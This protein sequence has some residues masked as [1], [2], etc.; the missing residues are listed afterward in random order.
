MSIIQFLKQKLMKSLRLN[1]VAAVT[2]IGLVGI[3]LLTFALVSGF[4]SPA[5]AEERYRN[6]VEL[7]AKTEEEAF[8]MIAEAERTRCLA[9]VD[10]ATKKVKAFYDEER[11]LQEG[12]DLQALVAKSQLTCDETS[13]VVQTAIEEVGNFS[14]PEGVGIDAFLAKNGAS[15]VKEAGDIFREA[16]KIHGI[17]PE[18]IVCI[19]QA[20]SSLGRALKSSNNIGNVGN[21]DRGDVVH[22]PDLRSGI[23]AIAKVLNNQYLG[24]YTTIGQ[25]SRGGGNKTGK[26]YASSAYNWNKNV[27]LCLRT[28]TGDQSVDES[29]QFRI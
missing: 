18:V 3:I 17:K 2:I 5:R 8:N 24:S 7:K 12:E 20:D 1:A 6:A 28:I 27:K 10:L 9:E 11:E 23:E 4:N 25:L 16:G 26:I 19:A 21:N 13:Q 29:F 22:Y 14:K 15:F